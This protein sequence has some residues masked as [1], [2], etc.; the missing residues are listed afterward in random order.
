ADPEFDRWLESNVKEQKQTGYAIVT[1]TVPQGNL[2]GAQMRAVAN[3]AEDAGDG[4]IRISVQQNLM[5]AYVP[6]SQLR[7]V[8]AALRL[9]DLGGS[10]AGEIT[11]VVTCP[12]AYSCNLALTKTMNL[13]AALVDHLQK[14]SDPEIRQLK[15]RAS[16]C[17]NACGHHW[18]GDIG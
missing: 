13:G 1:V 16:G 9:V 6:V 12:G 5:L 7:R 4:V 8:H 18:I 15:I 3:L 17:P 2:T 10:G 14:S 11:D